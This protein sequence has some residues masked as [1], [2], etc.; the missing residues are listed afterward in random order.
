[1][2]HVARFRIVLF[3]VNKLN[4]CC[5][6]KSQKEMVRHYQK[7]PHPRRKPNSGSFDGSQVY[8]NGTPCPIV[9][10]GTGHRKGK[11]KRRSMKDVEFIRRSL[12]RPLTSVKKKRRTEATRS[13][14]YTKAGHER[15]LK[16]VVKA[17]D[18]LR[19]RL[20]ESF[21]TPRGIRRVG[22]PTSKRMKQ[23]LVTACQVCKLL[24][25]RRFG[26]IR[27]GVRRIEKDFRDLKGKICLRAEKR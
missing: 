1:M 4:V 10:D 16:L 3:V 6:L 27:V 19:K 13:K 25:T 12:S 23:R 7:V 14:L 24:R 21:S 26:Q 17:V 2:R 9:A 8:F 22:R 15:R 11:K 20:R 5:S 18:L